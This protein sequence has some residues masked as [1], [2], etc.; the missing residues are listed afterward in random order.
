MVAQLFLVIFLGC[1]YLVI[2]AV[3]VSE[4]S[5]KYFLYAPEL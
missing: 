5:Y 1:A 4:H 2:S 3:P